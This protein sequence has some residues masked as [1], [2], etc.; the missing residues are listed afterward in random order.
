MT[1]L[2]QQKSLLFGLEWLPSKCYIEVI[3]VLNL[4]IAWYP[5][6]ITHNYLVNVGN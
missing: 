4:T 3:R 6:Q 1:V 2:K 5:I